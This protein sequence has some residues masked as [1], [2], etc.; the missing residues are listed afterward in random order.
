MPWVA[1]D[2]PSAN[3]DPT[4]PKGGKW[5]PIGSATPKKSESYGQIAKEAGQ[6]VA[7]Q[8]AGMAPIIA[9]A[10]TGALLGAGGGLGVGDIVT[11]PLG[12]MAGAGLGAM[13]SPT[14]RYYMGKLV[15]SK[16]PEPTVKEA[17][18]EGTVGAATEGMSGPASVISGGI[19]NPIF[20]SLVGKSELGDVGASAAQATE[21]ANA[22]KQA[23]LDEAAN[24]EM[25][26]NKATARGAAEQT[27]Q[28]NLAARANAYEKA[29]KDRENATAGQIGERRAAAQKAADKQAEFSRAHD[30][31]KAK[32]DAD[33]QKTSGKLQEQIVPE[34]RQETVAGTLNKTP[35]QTRSS[36]FDPN[37]VQNEAVKRDILFK[38]SN[39]ATAEYNKEY[40]DVRG[41][42]RD[43]PIALTN[44]AAAIKKLN[45]QATAGNWAL[46]ASTRRLLDESDQLSAAKADAP[47]PMAL[48]I[49]PKQWKAMSPA[50]QAL[51]LKNAAKLK[52][53]VEGPGIRPG[54]VKV[55][56][57]RPTAATPPTEE[58]PTGTTVGKTIGL[59]SKWGAQAGDSGSYDG[60]V[61]REMREAVLKDLDNANVPRLKELNNRYRAFR[62]GGLGDY[63]FLGKVSQPKAG[64]LH[65]VSGEIFNNPQRGMDFVKR[66]TPEEKPQFRDLY[67][68]YINTG[69]KI[70]PDHAPILAQ[71][72]FKGPLTKPEAWVYA[73]KQAKNLDEIFATSPNAK[74]KLQQQIQQAKADAEIQFNNDVIKQGYKDAN[75]LGATGARIKLKMDAAKTPAEKAQIAIQEFNNIQ[76][77]QAAQD[78]GRGQGP[79]PPDPNQVVSG[80]AARQQTPGGA[81][82]QSMSQAPRDAQMAA[83]NFQPQDAQAAAAKAIQEF[84]PARGKWAGYLMRR[85]AFGAI[86]GGGYGAMTGRIPPMLV[87]GG[88]GAGAVLGREGIAALWR[89]SIQESPEAAAA[90]YRGLQNPGTPAALHTFAQSAV[91][92]GITNYITQHGGSP[93]SEPTPSKGPG[94]MVKQVEHE[95]AVNIAGPRGAVSPARTSRIEDL[96]KDIAEG[97]EPEVH[98]DLRNGRLTHTDIAKMVQPDK[99]GVAGLFQGMSP[100]QAVDA[101]AV[102][103]PSERELGL[104]ALA[105]H[106]Q[107]SA[108]TTDPKQMAIAMQKL[109][110]IMAQQGATA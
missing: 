91:N 18:Y 29:Q 76:P 10:E 28:K 49:K 13:A 9:G 66:L 37:F 38:K 1:I 87:E 77:A 31:A 52:S 92:A 21:Q 23:K 51:T 75:A 64:E 5:V 98:A 2:D 80:M 27:G 34:A 85:A 8:G 83:R 100:V 61:A 22:D 68:D 74:A 55:E 94:P 16:Q 45:S 4:K 63:D 102:A 47:S 93:M 88:I 24:R 41:Q 109:K 89:S 104:S 35:G 20:D 53:S 90:F 82:Y 26:S 3:P 106:L 25:A 44:T 60:L 40:E 65:N 71:L 105:Q 86:G 43:K 81:A 7:V 14:A 17:N 48:G 19:V 62:N 36:R 30:E 33:F 101:F 46:S 103:D 50:E 69:G 12:A 99:G 70:S 72:G 73:D 84:S 79:L 67:A 95:K 6:N 15:G 96:N 108:K 107:D 56:G 32:A 39:E 110:S 42:F 58:A 59:N 78:V 57:N 54:L 11:V 97:K